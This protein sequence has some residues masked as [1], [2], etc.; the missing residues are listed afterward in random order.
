MLAMA[1]ETCGQTC[2]DGTGRV[3]LDCYSTMR[4][5]D[6]NASR[7]TALKEQVRKFYRV[8]WDAHDRNASVLHDDFTFRGSLGDERRGHKGFAEYVDKVHSALGDYRCVIEVLVEE[9]A[10]VFAKMSFGGIHRGRFMGYKLSGKRVYW[11]G[12]ALFT[13]Q[14]L[15]WSDLW[16]VGDLRGLEDQLKRNSS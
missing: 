7:T 6:A 13:F 4:E 16:V 3:G 15:R 8:L 14:G 12:C 1:T 11:S 2:G 9:G 5:A 10:K